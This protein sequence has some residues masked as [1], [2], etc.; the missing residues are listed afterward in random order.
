M[1]A[2]RNF[3]DA[4]K[5]RIKSPTYRFRA[6]Y[7]ASLFA[8]TMVATLCHSLSASEITWIDG[9]TYTVTLK[10]TP[11]PDPAVV[12]FSTPVVSGPIASNSY[13]LHTQNMTESGDGWY[14]APNLGQTQKAYLQARI[15]SA[16]KPGQ[17]STFT[18][19]RKTNVTPDGTKNLKDSRAWPEGTYPNHYLGR[20]LRSG[21]HQFAIENGDGK[22]VYYDPIKTPTGWTVA[23]FKMPTSNNK[24]QTITEEVTY[25]NPKGASN[26]EVKITVDGVTVLNASG[27]ICNAGRT[28]FGVQMVYA[29]NTGD[30]GPLPSNATFEAKIIGVSVR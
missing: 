24:E 17:T 25:S 1:I 20:S 15:Q 30:S 26:G 28:A 2:L 21:S 11:A 10:E 12:V 7:G 18:Y 4:A 23:Y 6:V 29:P 9:K 16:T 14:K 13:S 19:I 27:A 8:L 3:S 22:V 5:L